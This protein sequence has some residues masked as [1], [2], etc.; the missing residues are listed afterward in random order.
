MGVSGRKKK[1]GTTLKKLLEVVVAP[2]VVAILVVTLSPLGE[3]LKHVVFPTSPP[4]TSQINVVDDKN[5]SLK[6][7]AQISSTSISFRFSGTDKAQGISYRCIIDGIE[8][9]NPCFSPTYI[10]K[11]EVGNHTFS[12]KA[13]DNEKTEDPTPTTFG[14]T[15]ISS[16]VVEPAPSNKPSPTKPPTNTTT[17]TNLVVHDLNIPDPNYATKSFKVNVTGATVNDKL[18]Y[19]I[20]DKPKHGNITSF[21]SNTGEGIYR[22]YVQGELS[23]NPFTNQDSFSVKVTNKGTS[24]GIATVNIFLSSILD[25]LY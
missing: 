12:V 18:N 24:I 16:P 7:G 14:F 13:V 21:D 2:L 19:I 15:V 10:S 4:E 25:K 1:E 6:N 22:P 8:N 20:I 5:Q 9:S 3:I 23:Y 17:Q 11:W